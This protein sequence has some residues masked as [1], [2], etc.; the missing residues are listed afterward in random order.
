MSIEKRMTRDGA[1]RY[2]ARVKSNSKL[3]ASQTFRR[4]RDAAV[5]ERE[6]YR[7]LAFGQFIPPSQS[8]ILFA[9]VAAAFLESRHGQVTPH[10]WRTDRDNLAGIPAWFSALPVASIGPSQIL[11][12]LTE[13]LAIKARST[14][15]RARTTLSAVFAYAVRERML[16][17]NPVRDV[18][19]PSGGHP[20]SR[21]VETFTDAQLEQSLAAQ[22]EVH[23][24]LASVTE[25]FSLTGLRW[26]ELRALR[27]GDVHSAPMPALRIW[28]AQSDGYA[29]AGTKTSNVRLVPLTD[30]AQEIAAA[31]A[32]NRHPDE[33]LALSATGKQLQ[34]SGFRWAVKWSETV[35]PGRTIN[36]LR[37]YAA[38]AWLRAGI[39]VHQVAR[40]LGHAN[41]NTTLRVYAHVLGEAQDLAAVAQ[42]NA[43]GADLSDA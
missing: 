43:R 29:E 17:G 42:L 16:T 32:T 35:P 37:H 41:A 30:R 14:T 33:Y 25:F 10:S 31:L 2:V 28:H 23:A 5:W 26:S 11:R 20:A 18:R 40:W 8:A 6:Q 19:M 15:Q 24:R 36:D 12:Y 13:Q 39:P 3:V 4:K 22:H 38:S 9:N 1:A 34:G 27:V 21:G 7:A